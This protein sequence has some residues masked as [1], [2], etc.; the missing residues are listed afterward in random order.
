MAEVSNKLLEQVLRKDASDPTWDTRLPQAAKSVNTRIIPYLGLSPSAIMLGP[1]QK[2][3][4]TIAT[5]QA[6]PGRSIKTWHDELLDPPIHRKAVHNYH[7][8]IAKVHDVVT[9][10]TARRHEMEVHRY[11][12]GIKRVIHNIGDLVMLFQKDVGK[13]QPRWRGHFRINR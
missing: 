9:E 10:T 13:L 1:A 3:S 5:L 2:T 6:L 11:N 12:R 4:S 7:R 8:H